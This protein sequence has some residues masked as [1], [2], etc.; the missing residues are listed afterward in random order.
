MSTRRVIAHVLLCVVAFIVVLALVRPKTKVGVIGSFSER[1]V[2]EIETVCAKRLRADMR[3]EVVWALRHH[4]LRA[5]AD[6]LR[7][8]H[9]LDLHSIERVSADL[10][11]NDCPWPGDAKAWIASGGIIKWG[12]LLEQTNGVWRITFIGLDPP[13]RNA[14]HTMQALVGGMFGIVGLVEGGGAVYAAGAGVGEL[15]FEL[16]NVRGKGAELSRVAA[17]F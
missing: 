2:A 1:D 5:L 8:R 13:K 3:Y 15:F 14:E 7:R 6:S 11:D 16:G 17:G 10:L 12:Y 9:Q 4:S